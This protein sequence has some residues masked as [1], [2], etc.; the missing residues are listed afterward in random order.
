MKQICRSNKFGRG[1]KFVKN[2]KF[3]KNFFWFLGFSR[4]SGQAREFAE[5]QHHQ[6]A[7]KSLEHEISPKNVEI[8]EIITEDNKA[9]T[10]WAYFSKDKV[11]WQKR[12]DSVKPPANSQNKQLCEKEK[13]FVKHEVDF[14]KYVQC[15]WQMERLHLFGKCFLESVQKP[16]KFS[17]RHDICGK[18]WEVHNKKRKKD[19]L[20]CLRKSA[21][22]NINLV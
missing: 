21:K 3:V 20:R 22:K 15:L 19:K 6:R 18:P 4:I 16:R 12:S 5:K 13:H 14:E 2:C 10:E 7:A 11:I 17:K 9:V 1:D 8:K